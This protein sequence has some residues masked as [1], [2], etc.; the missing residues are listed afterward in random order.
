MEY[1]GFVPRWVLHASFAE[2]LK[3]LTTCAGGREMD[4]CSDRIY[5][6]CKPDG[7]SRIRASVG[8]CQLRLLSG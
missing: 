4:G 6:V 2:R 1:R 5:P 7:T 3:P 8:V